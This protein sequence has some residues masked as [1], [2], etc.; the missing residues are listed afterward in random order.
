MARNASGGKQGEHNR[1]A[2]TGRYVTKEYADAHRSTTVN[3]TKS[4]G[5]KPRSKSK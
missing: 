2:I 1:S 4:G 3:E 5:S